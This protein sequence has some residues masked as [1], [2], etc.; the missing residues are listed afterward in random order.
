VRTIAEIRAELEG[1]SRRRA[2]LWE[3]LSQHGHDP[4]ASAEAAE[5]SRR[6]EDLWAEQRAVL[7]HRRHGPVERIHAR[8]RAEER[9]EREARRQRKAA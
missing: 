9:L 8:A 7:A 6:I 3:T 1:A 5:L 4:E 2:H